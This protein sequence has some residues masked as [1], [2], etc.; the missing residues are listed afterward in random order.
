MP[1]EGKRDTSSSSGKALRRIY[2]VGHEN[3]QHSRDLETEFLKGV[4][5]LEELGSEGLSS[6]FSSLENLSTLTAGISL[7]GDS[8][9][10]CRSPLQTDQVGSPLSSGDL[11]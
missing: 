8:F 5:P 2:E 9:W 10:Q 3:S 4:I 7:L 1:C 11:T 6:P